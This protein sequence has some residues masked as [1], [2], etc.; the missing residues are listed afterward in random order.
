[1]GNSY[2]MSDG[3]R[4]AK[5]EI[6]QKVREAKQKKIDMM[7]EEQ[8][9][10]VCEDC[11]RNDCVPVDCSH[12]ISVKECQESGRTELAWDVNNITMRGRKC[13]QKHDKTYIGR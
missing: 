2:K 12:D 1:M 9:Y 8:G 7:M 13:H 11:G 6:D 5:S 10:I 3:T 4:M